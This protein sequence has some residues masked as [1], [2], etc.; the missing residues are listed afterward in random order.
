MKNLKVFRVRM[1]EIWS[2]GEQTCEVEE[3]TQIKSAP[4]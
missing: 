3:M 1:R 2:S 4:R